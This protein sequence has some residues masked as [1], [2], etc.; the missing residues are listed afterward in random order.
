MADPGILLFFKV[1]V[2]N[3]NLGLFTSF[4]GLGVEVVLEQRE[5]GG[6]SEFVHQLPVRLKY[7]NV[8]LTRPLDADSSAVAT[9]IASM[10]G[11]LVRTTATIT[12]LGADLNAMCAWHLVEVFPARWQGPAFNTESAKMATETLEL[13]HHGFRFEKMS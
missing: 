5:E 3:H 8:K 9:W 11:K 10:S 7:S 1:E 2:A 6:N 12:A 4:D 13:A